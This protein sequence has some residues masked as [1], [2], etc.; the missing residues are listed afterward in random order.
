MMSRLRPVFCFAALALTA[1]VAQANPYS[2]QVLRTRAVPGPH[3]QVTYGVDN[4]GGSSSVEIP[5]LA[6]TY[7]SKQTSWDTMSGFKAN[8]GS[9]V[10][11]L[12]AV[13]SCDCFVPKGIALAYTTTLPDRISSTYGRTITITLQSTITV[14]DSYDAAVWPD[15]RTDGAAWNDPEPTEVQGLDCTAACARENLDASADAPV[16][17][18][19]DAL[20]T[21][22]DSSTLTIDAPKDLS[23]PLADADIALG[24]TPLATVDAP[25]VTAPAPEAT[26]KGSKGCSFGGSAPSSPLPLLGLLALLALGRRR[27]S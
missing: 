3:V 26:L 7:G 19:E 9:G 23:M 20:G 14:T 1:G 21:L 16:A 24:D 25:V 15:S 6:S 10:V 2:L 12:Q 18:S 8:T 17:L 4:R 22:S 11:W 5:T 27:H 13:Q